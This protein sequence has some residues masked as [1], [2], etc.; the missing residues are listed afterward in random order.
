MNNRPHPEAPGPDVF[1]L[2]AGFSRAIYENMPLMEDLGFQVRKF[3]EIDPYAQ[4]ISQDI[5]QFLTFLATDQ[6]WLAESTRLRNQALFL[7]ATRVIEEVILYNENY[8]AQDDMPDWLG[9][10]VTHWHQQQAVVIS[11]NYDTLVERA[12]KAMVNKSAGDLYPLGLSNAATR[13]NS[14]YGPDR[15]PT[16]RLCK[17]HGSLNWYYSGTRYST[18][19]TVY[20]VPVSGWGQDDDGEKMAQDYV[21][22]KVPYLIPPTTEK[23]SLFRHE[24]LRS[25]WSSAA[26][27]I[28]E[29]D[30]VYALG[31]SFPMTDLGMSFLLKHNSMPRAGKSP[32]HLAVINSSTQAQENA[33]RLIGS[34][35]EVSASEPRADSIPEFVSNLSINRG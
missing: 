3:V 30:N 33:V 12:A 24:T 10:L 27:A 7:E 11:L 17:L 19:E 15:N 5:E 4:S 18:G 9:K 22:D 14:L 35:Y 2:G 25:I 16:L 21:M 1:I 29:A 6:P 13:D 20:Y 26:K 31:Y 28:R 34:D 8:V 32:K 23:S